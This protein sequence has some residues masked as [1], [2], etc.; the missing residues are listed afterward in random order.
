MTELVIRIERMEFNGV[1][2]QIAQTTN[3]RYIATVRLWGLKRFI[4]M[5]AESREEA[6]SL[7]H[8]FID[9]TYPKENNE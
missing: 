5:A 1:G 6:N 4:N 8:V 9:A 7:A 2:Y 3:G